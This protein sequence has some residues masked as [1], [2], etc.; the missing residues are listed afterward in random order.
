MGFPADALV[1]MLSIASLV[2][3]GKK[4]DSNQRVNAGGRGGAG[5]QK[6]VG[7]NAYTSSCACNLLPFQI[8]QLL[9]CQLPAQSLSD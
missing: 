6:G 7:G 8:S 3:D 1:G 5:G 9:T 2:V 4:E